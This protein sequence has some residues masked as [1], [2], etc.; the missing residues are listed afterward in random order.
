MATERTLAASFRR[1]AGPSSLSLLPGFFSLMHKSICTRTSWSKYRTNRTATARR[2]NNGNVHSAA[3]QSLQ[4]DSSRMKKPSTTLFWA[5][6][7]FAMVAIVAQPCTPLLTIDDI[8]ASEMIVGDVESGCEEGHGYT[9]MLLIL[10]LAYASLL[11]LSLLNALSS[12]YWSPFTGF[13]LY[14]VR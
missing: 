2:T 5:A 8:E 10:V 7:F 6:S 1:Q 14:R 13:S 11:S 3:Y 9:G 4:V 12:S